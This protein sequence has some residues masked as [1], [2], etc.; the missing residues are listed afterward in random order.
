MPPTEDNPPMRL[1]RSSPCIICM[2]LKFCAIL[3]AICGMG[4]GVVRV[5]CWLYWDCGCC[6]WD[7]GWGCCTGC[8]WRCWDCS[9]DCWLEVGCDWVVLGTCWGWLLVLVLLEVG[10]FW[11]LWLIS[12][13]QV[14][15]TLL[16]EFKDCRT[17]IKPDRRLVLLLLVSAILSKRLSCSIERELWWW[18]RRKYLIT[19]SG[20]RF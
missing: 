8:C 5:G 16:A 4:G 18:R 6:T 17:G 13:R 20:V 12:V 7:Y 15:A 14:I 9:F 11:F 19:P 3:G 10:W 1:P 2:G